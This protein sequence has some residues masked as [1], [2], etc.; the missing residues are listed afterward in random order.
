MAIAGVLAGAGAVGYVL[1]RPVTGPVPGKVRAERTSALYAPIATRR[2]DPRPLTAEEVFGRAGTMSAAGVTMHR[3]QV[4][5]SA[6]CAQALWGEPLTAA[7]AGCVQVVRAGFADAAGGVSGQYT[8]FDMPEESAAD[9]LVAALR[10]RP[11][12]G[13][14]TLAPGQP[15]S[16]DAGHSRAEVRALGHFVVVNW[17]GPVSDAGPADVTLAQVALEGLGGFVQARVLDAAG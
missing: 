5:A 16:F 8:V 4:S 7:A 13:F 1:L 2:D 14:L 10:A 17:V 9:R 6:D 11:A 12:E 3:R 15:P